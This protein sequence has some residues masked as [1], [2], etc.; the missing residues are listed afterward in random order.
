MTVRPI[1]AVCHHAVESFVE[2]EDAGWERWILVAKCHGEVERV[3]IRFSEVKSGPIF[4]G[5]AF[6]DSPKRPTQ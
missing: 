3:T 6:T 5:L 4:I 2:T 1:C